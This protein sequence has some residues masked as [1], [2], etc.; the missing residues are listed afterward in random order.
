MIRGSIHDTLGNYAQGL[1]FTDDEK[2]ALANN[3]A[4]KQIERSLAR[5][6]TGQG[7]GPAFA[8]IRGARE[9]IRITALSLL[10]IDAHPVANVYNPVARVANSAINE[11]L[12]GFDRSLFNIRNGTL[13]G[14]NAKPADTDAD[15]YM[16][17]AD[18]FS[19]MLKRLGVS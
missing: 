8:D 13:A 9:T 10:N 17:S 11:W 5:I 4:V 2:Q 3:A 6:A 12:G 7:L 16:N 14:A 18:L 15:G 1:I 19:Y